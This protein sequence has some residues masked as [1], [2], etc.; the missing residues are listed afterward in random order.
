[1]QVEPQPSRRPRTAR[2]IGS[3]EYRPHDARTFDATCGGSRHSPATRLP[4]IPTELSSHSDGATGTQR[5]LAAVCC[6]FGAWPL[7]RRPVGAVRGCGWGCGS[8]SAC[9]ISSA[10]W[11]LVDRRLS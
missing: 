1:L 4:R 7:R 5:C 10:E 11:R 2:L 3:S 9:V 6:R 8:L